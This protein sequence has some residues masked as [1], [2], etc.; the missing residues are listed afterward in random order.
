MCIGSHHMPAI[1]YLF[2]AARLHCFAVSDQFLCTLSMGAAKW[3]LQLPCPIVS[4]AVVIYKQ[5]GWWCPCYL[6]S[7]LCSLNTS[8]PDMSSWPRMWQTSW[9]SN[10]FVGLV[11]HDKARQA[12]SGHCASCSYVAFASTIS[13]HD[14]T[15]GYHKPSLLCNPEFCGVA[16]TWPQYS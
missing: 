11:R 7:P 13:F 16:S 5:E 3:Q 8:T 10:C 4:C 1:S 12:D 9:R 6:H 15:C 14:A 2:L